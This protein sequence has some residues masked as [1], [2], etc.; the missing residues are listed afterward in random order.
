MSK[1]RD[2]ATDKDTGCLRAPRHTC[3]AH[4]ASGCPP[5][6]PAPAPLS[7]GLRLPVAVPGQASSGQPA[8]SSPLIVPEAQPSTS[9]K[10][11]RPEQPP[12]RADMRTLTQKLPRVSSWPGPL[13]GTQVPCGSAGTE[14]L[15]PAT[16]GQGWV[17]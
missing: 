15:W 13:P 12:L 1:S 9:G 3:S 2:T 4:E 6:A 11:P 10:S 7:R 8:S 17:E 16:P 14:A 5:P